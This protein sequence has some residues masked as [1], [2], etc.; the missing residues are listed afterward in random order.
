[1]SASPKEVAGTLLTKEYLFNINHL[2]EIT[3]RL[4]CFNKEELTEFFKEYSVRLGSI[5]SDLEDTKL[6]ILKSSQI[7]KEKLAN[8]PELEQTLTSYLKD[9]F[10]EPVGATT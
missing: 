4:K 1:M 3:E 7:W 8:S 2:P 5:I 10:Y 9:K 6:A